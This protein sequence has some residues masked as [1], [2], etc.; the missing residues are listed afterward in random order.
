MRQR[1]LRIP[2]PARQCEACGTEFV[3]YRASSKYCR[4][5]CTARA[6]KERDPAGQR[7][8]QRERHRRYLEAHRD[9]VLARGREKAKQHRERVGREVL[10]ERARA[11]Y[12]LD[13]EKA[14]KKALAQAATP[15]GRA[16]GLCR[17]A[18]TRAKERGLPF[19]MEVDDI[20]RRIRAGHCEASGVPFDLS[21]GHGAGLRPWA[22]SLDRTD[23]TKGYTPDNV[24]VVAWIYNAAKSHWTH[25][26][27]MRLAR[28]LTAATAFVQGA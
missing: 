17:Q 15:R 9:E 1:E 8:K 7:Q 10:A 23:P 12:W 25:D 21:F 20:E 22:P 26:D 3:P 4:R 2:I 24:R 27:V 6:V 28:A 18:K 11:I 14:R 5:K 19:A 13:P 16:G